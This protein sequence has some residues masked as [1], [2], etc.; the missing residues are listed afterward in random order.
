MG[1]IFDL[2]QTLVNSTSAK[3]YRDERKWPDV[4]HKIKEFEL[5]DGIDKVLDYLVEKKIEIVIV[6]SSPKRYCQLVVEH[7]GLTVSDIV[8]YHD[9]E[10]HKPSPQP[11]IKALSKMSDKLVLS[12]G[13]D[14][15]DIKA[16]N[17]ANVISVGCTWGTDDLVALRGSNPKHICESTIELLDLICSYGDRL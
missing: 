16:S 14:Y 11:I 3:R 17:S 13:D 9:T 1:V 10:L 8:C 4:Y 2:D 5:Y 12:F 15:K 6:T 7:F